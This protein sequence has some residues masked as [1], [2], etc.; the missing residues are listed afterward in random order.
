MTVLQSLDSYYARMAARGEASL[1][2]YAREKIDFV[3]ILS[4][5]GQ[6]ASVLSLRRVEGKRQVPQPLDVPAGSK[7]LQG[8][9][10]TYCG[11]RPL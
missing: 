7:A 6:S 9:R 11:T 10:R 5:D 2:G 3:V 4:A 8:S 1:P